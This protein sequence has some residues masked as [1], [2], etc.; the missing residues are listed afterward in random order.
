M[1]LVL[2]AEA[3]RV[4]GVRMRGVGE[5][6]VVD[7]DMGGA[8][9][10]DGVVGGVPVAGGAVGRVPLREAVPDVG[11]RQVAD[12]HVVGVLHHEA[13]AGDARSGAGHAYERGRAGTVNTMRAACLDWAALR[14]FSWVP[15]GTLARPQ[16]AGS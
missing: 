15:D 9:Q 1:H 11:E 12:D 13:A 2:A 10:A 7:P 8:A 3:D 4:G 5:A 16:T 14:A 6:V